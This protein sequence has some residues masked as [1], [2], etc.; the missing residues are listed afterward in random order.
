MQKAKGFGAVSWLGL[1]EEQVH[2]GLAMFCST[3]LVKDKH[4]RL[5]V[6]EF[7]VHASHT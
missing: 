7:H 1:E 3:P 6:L 5:V 2:H 4:C